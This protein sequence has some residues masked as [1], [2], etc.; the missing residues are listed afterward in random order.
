M[1]GLA[2]PGLDPPGVEKRTVWYLTHLTRTLVGMLQRTN[3][4]VTRKAEGH[5]DTCW[6]LLGHKG[7]QW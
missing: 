3:S 1:M 4:A 6:L 2:V 7:P 5:S